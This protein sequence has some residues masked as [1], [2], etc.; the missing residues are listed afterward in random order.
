MF[1]TIVVVGYLLH[2]SYKPINLLKFSISS[3]II[4][5]EVSKVKKRIL[6][7]AFSITIIAILIV[8]YFT[9]NVNKNDVG[10]A[11]YIYGEKNIETEISPEDMA[12]IADIFNKKSINIL[13]MPS[14]GF[15]ENIAVVIGNKT[16]CVA[17]D[18]CGTVYFKERKGYLLLN[19]NENE[20]LR[21]ILSDYGFE[22]PCV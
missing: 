4:N 10:T 15:D 14:C 16:F 8:G 3:F 1:L 21:K 19:D 12:V 5:L 22:W 6:I 20:Q 2:F 9:V 13:E 18:K 17:C 11:R 7:I